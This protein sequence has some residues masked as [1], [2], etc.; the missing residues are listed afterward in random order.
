MTR[1]IVQTA[2]DHLQQLDPVN[3]HIYEHA[4]TI[5][6]E[7]RHIPFLVLDFPTLPITVYRSRTHENDNLFENFSDIGLPPAVAVSGFGRCN[8][9]GQPVFYCSDSRGTSFLELLEYWAEEKKNPYLY[10]TIG[11][12]TIN[13]SFRVVIITSPYAAERAYVRL[14]S[15]SG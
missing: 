6:E 3:P 7:M 13:R 15:S 10:V 8:V 9:P 1:Q 5:F 12:W 4:I 14:R 2:V 11:R